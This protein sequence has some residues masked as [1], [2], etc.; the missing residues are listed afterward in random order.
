MKKSNKSVKPRPVDASDKPPEG[1]T[2]E[3]PEGQKRINSVESAIHRLL[4]ACPQQVV[5]RLNDY[6]RETDTEAATLIYAWAECGRR[7]HQRTPDLVLC[8]TALRTVT[9][10]GLAC[11]VAY[12]RAWIDEEQAIIA[13]A[14]QA[15]R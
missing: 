14:Q 2:C 10:L 8:P 3:L 12:A 11:L 5:S 7:D 6:L 4:D 15:L 1:I 9:P 13:R